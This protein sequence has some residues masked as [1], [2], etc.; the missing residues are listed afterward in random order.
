MSTTQSAGVI[1]SYLAGT[2][3]KESV[4]YLP[5]SGVTIDGPTTGMVARPTTSPSRSRRRQRPRLSTTRWT[6]PTR[7]AD[8]ERQQQSHGG[9]DLY[10]GHG[11]EK[12]LSVTVSENDLGTVQATHK[13]HH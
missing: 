2:T 4:P 11:G 13:I 5:M 10:M 6:P 7:P 8:P 1:G 12:T 9:S 3:T